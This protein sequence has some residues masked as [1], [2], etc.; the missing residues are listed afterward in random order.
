MTH[1]IPFSFIQGEPLP[2]PHFFGYPE[3]TPKKTYDIIIPESLSMSEGDIVVMCHHPE[4]IYHKELT[5]KYIVERRK[6]KG[7]WSKQLIHKAPHF[8]RFISEK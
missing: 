1:K 7:D 5:V 6:A 2:V 3:Y 8:V 4:S